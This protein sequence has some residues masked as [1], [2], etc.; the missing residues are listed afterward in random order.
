MTLD[1]Q[2]SLQP[3]S[4]PWTGD[5]FSSGEFT[6]SHTH[7]AEDSQDPVQGKWLLRAQQRR[8]TS[9]GRESERGGGTEH[10]GRENRKG[11]LPLGYP[12]QTLHFQFSILLRYL[13]NVCF[14][15]SV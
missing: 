2:H 8:H 9:T 12:Q 1:C 11:S 6:R 3:C 13:L 7:H 14:S 15:F 5:D 10:S 4:L